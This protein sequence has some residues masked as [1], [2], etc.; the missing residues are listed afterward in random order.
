MSVRLTREKR[1]A[2]RL[3]LKVE[4]EVKIPKR[5]TVAITM[6][7]TGGKKH[8]RREPISLSVSGGNGCQLSGFGEKAE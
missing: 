5:P 8:E 2:A 1:L 4:T 3:R 7:Y 6:G